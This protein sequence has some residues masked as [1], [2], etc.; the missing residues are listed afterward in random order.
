MEL[1][2]ETL[3]GETVDAIIYQLLRIIELL[4]DGFTT[5]YQPS[6][7]LKTLSDYNFEY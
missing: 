1:E 7:S 3:E 5:G 2:I 4:E 6:F